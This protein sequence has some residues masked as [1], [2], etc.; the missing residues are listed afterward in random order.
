MAD[1]RTIPTRKPRGARVFGAAAA[2]DATEARVSSLA[3]QAANQ[4]TELLITFKA[5]Q[6]LERFISPEYE[7]EVDDSVSPSRSEL[8]SLL[9]TLNA[10]MQRQIGALADTTTVLQAQVERKAA[11]ASSPPPP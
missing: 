4:V 6:A 5:Y 7:H 1:Q 2:A 9:H 8:G 11:S 3:L 10:E